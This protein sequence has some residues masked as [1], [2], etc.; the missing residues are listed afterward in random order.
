V[1]K[2]AM[3]STEAALKSHKEAFSIVSKK[4]VQGM[5]PQIEHIKA[6]DDYTGAEISHIIAIY[7]YYIKEA[8]LESVSAINASN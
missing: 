1:A 5:V 4:Y 3:I 6:R 8:Q 2:K 7:D